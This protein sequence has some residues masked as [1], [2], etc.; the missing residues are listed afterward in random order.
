MKIRL[1]Q[2]V[3]CTDGVFGELGDIVIDPQRRTVTHLVVEPHHQHQQARL[4][5]M[6]LI[7]IDGDVVTVDLD[8]DH[9]RQLQRVAN[10]DFIKLGER[11][12]VG[13]DWDIGTED[14]VSM[15]FWDFENGI[16]MTPYDNLIDVSYDRIP[17][18]DCE[19]RRQSDVLT[20]DDRIVGDVEGFLADEDHLVAVIVRSGRI[21]IRQSVIVPMSKVSEVRTDEIVLSMDKLEFSALPKAEGLD[22]SFSQSKFEAYEKRAGA[23]FGRVTSGV[24]GLSSKVKR[25]IERKSTDA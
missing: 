20:S 3:H 4:V 8:S 15:P 25:L 18:G 14:L 19:I 11:P 10:R 22:A 17:K 23:L 13:D 9:L 7:A 16:V 21:G 12:D 24:R 5:P 1:G 2:P 6:S